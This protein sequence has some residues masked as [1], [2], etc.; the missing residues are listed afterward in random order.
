[1]SDTPVRVAPRA[2]TRLQI[3]ATTDLHMHLFSHDYYRDQPAPTV[4][5][6][7][8]A[9]LIAG[10]RAATRAAGGLSILL[11]NGDFLQGTPMG[12]LMAR[13][14]GDKGGNP[15]PMIAAMNHLGYDAI[16]LGNHDLDYGL[17]FLADTLGQANFA[18]LCSNL[19]LFGDAPTTAQLQLAVRPWQILHRHMPLPDG[20]TAPLRI[21][22]VSFLPPQVNDWCRG[23]LRDCGHVADILDTARTLVPQVRA[24]G[25]DVVVA[26][27]HSGLG[28]PDATNGLENAAI[29]LTT[30]PGLDAVIAGH[31]HQVF[32]SNAFGAVPQ[33]DPVAGTVLGKPMTM[34]GF[35]GS[36]L[37]VI[38]LDM[39]MQSGA[40]HPRWSVLAA[41]GR[42]IEI[43]ASM[44]PDPAIL[45]IAEAD[46]RA[47]LA[48]VRQPIGH[49]PMALNTFFAR[50]APSECTRV[51]AQAQRNRAEILVAGTAVAQ[52]PLLS[53]SAPFNAGGNRRAVGYTDIAPGNLALRHLADLYPFPNHLGIVRVTGA[54]IKDWLEHSAGM[55]HQITPGQHDQLLIKPDFPGY[56][57]DTIYG[58]QYEIDLTQPARFSPQ[59]VMLNRAAHRIRNLRHGAALLDSGADFLVATNSYRAGGG[60]DFPHL[61]N[62]AALVIDTT[63][64]VLDL[65]VEDLTSSGAFASP[66]PRSPLTWRFTDVPDTSA[67][68]ETGPQAKAHLAS[69]P[70]HMRI[71][72]IDSDAPEVGRFRIW[73]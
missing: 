41:R 34:P 47:T 17:G 12:D 15:H 31:S 4:G 32:P 10:A 20:T 44:P 29:A 40:D 70:P 22:L 43:T 16:G 27:A 45:E 19:R 9:P 8:I 42:A 33:V 46:H 65:L 21:G 62:G 57:F 50:A 72:P 36:H 56:N 28:P 61:R 6:A 23:T 67:V 58:L 63:I 53:A 3:L 37:G 38:E 60:G 30:V 25:A 18:V 13:R 5:L 69:L 35:W 49:S 48:M 73:L 71:E 24:A 1:M 26:L 2:T 11:D 51:V 55:F 64:S 59:G 39:G 7:K 14:A 52:L 66:P 68:F 54:Q